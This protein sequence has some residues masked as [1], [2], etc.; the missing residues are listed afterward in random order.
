MDI[1]KRLQ[2][3]LSDRHRALLQQGMN[4]LGI[5]KAEAVNRAIEGF[6]KMAAMQRKNEN[7]RVPSK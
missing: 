6:A 1:P 5:S 3:V 2:I 4:D 7:E